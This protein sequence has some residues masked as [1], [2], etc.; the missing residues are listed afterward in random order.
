VPSFIIDPELV[1]DFL[2]ESGE[3]LEQLDADLIRLEST[4]QDPELLNCVFRALHTIKGS[5]SFLA[6]TNLVAIAHVAESSLNA[7]RNRL[8][9]VDRPVMDCLLA[10]VDIIKI[11]FV[12]LRAGEDLAAADAALIAKLAAYGES[13]AI[14]AHASPAAPEANAGQSAPTVGRTEQTNVSPLSLSSGKADLLDFLISD[15]NATLSVI[16]D[17]VGK[18]A[19]EHAR[20]EA[21]ASIADLT[22]SL[23]RSVDFFEFDSMTRHVGLLGQVANAVPQLATATVTTLLPRVNELLE[24]L[25]EQ[26]LGLANKQLVSMPCAD[27]V[28]KINT[29][30]NDGGAE[31]GPGGPATESHPAATPSTPVTPAAS[32]TS[33]TPTTPATPGIASAK[34]AATAQLPD[35]AGAPGPAPATKKPEGSSAPAGQDQTIR[36][37]VSRLESLLN[38]IGELVLQKNR[39]SA[40]TRQL[41]ANGFGTQEFR[42]SFTQASGSLD[43]VTSDLQTAVMKT[44]M[45]PLDKIFGKYPRLLRDLSR[46]LNKDINLVIEGG[47]TEVDKSVIEELGDPL[48]HLMRNSADHGVE[49]PA[50]RI[51]AGKSSTGT[52][53]LSASHRGSH[54]EILIKDDGRGLCRERL[55]KKALEKG[56]Y[57]EDQLAAM[58]DKEVC[59]II[60]AAGFSTAEQLSDVSGRG[61]GMDVVRANIEKLKGT[62]DLYS[63]P[64][65]GTT[66]AI[67]IP[68]TVAIMSAMMV[69]VGKEIY[70]VPLSNIIEIVKP[71]PEQL[72]SIRRSPVMRL[73][74]G[75]LPLL[76]AGNLFGKPSATAKDSPFAV[77]M[78]LSDTRIGLLVSRLIGQQEIV[79]KP[80]DDFLDNGG[81][82]SG[83]TVRD[84]GGVS[85]IVDVA[86]CFQLAAQTNAAICHTT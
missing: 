52:I 17:S 54:V 8:L 34:V 71:S 23:A 73:R 38:L 19:D 1:A 43:R 22:I 21:S 47:D 30:I 76:D 48:I 66:V 33:T 45:Q 78:Q 25:K 86:R 14:G 20:A 83:A 46:K 59:R 61:V 35:V 32:A 63:E 70:A 31:I 56:L 51:K 69:G 10:A 84:D 15:L 79:I 55:S 85:L 77:V 40:L 67:L 72:Y 26:S 81:P 2:T 42:E 7:A 60:F 65:K 58:T 68:L 5:A 4:P 64:G 36:V 74:D 37:E 12:N 82:V 27:L 16:E 41:T 80:L 6:L 62:I 18:L 57:T 3:L 44:R 53:T 39:V 28:S 29:L 11:Q 75:V 13:K 9:T 49:S 50:D 24:I